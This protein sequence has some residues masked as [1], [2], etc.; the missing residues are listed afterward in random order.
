MPEKRKWFQVLQGW[1]DSTDS[2]RDV[3]LAAFAAVVIASIVWL[4]REQARGP[5]RPEWVDALKWLLA[6][7]SLGSAAWAA[8]DKWR[9]RNATDPTPAPGGPDNDGG[10]K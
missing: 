3:K 6:A 2:T 8:V 9:S 1:M 10:E 4:S 5:I 7:T